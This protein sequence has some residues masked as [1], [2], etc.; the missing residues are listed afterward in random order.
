[1]KILLDGQKNNN[2]TPANLLTAKLFRTDEKQIIPFK[3]ASARN[4]PHK[5]KNDKSNKILCIY[6]LQMCIELNILMHYLAYMLTYMMTSTNAPSD[7]R[8]NRWI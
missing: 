3:T 5:K 1:M 7:A 2:L 4:P 6:G 8:K